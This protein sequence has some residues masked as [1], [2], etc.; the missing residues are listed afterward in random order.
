[1]AQKDLKPL[2]TRTKEE[3]KRIAKMGG[4]A[5]G[6]ARKEKKMLKDTLIALLEIEEKKGITGQDNICIAL[7]K[8]A[9]CGDTKAFE[10]IRDTIG[11][12]PI[13]KIEKTERPII[14]DDI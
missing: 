2:N 8:R 12:K 6:R 1:M 9:K 11:Q 7:V 3:Q 5:S 10:I 14:K 4:I 13:E